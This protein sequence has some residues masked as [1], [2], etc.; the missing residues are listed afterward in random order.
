MRGCGAVFLGFVV[1][2]KVIDRLVNAVRVTIITV[3]EADRIFILR[4]LISGC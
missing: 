2:G 1:S 4:V 3:A